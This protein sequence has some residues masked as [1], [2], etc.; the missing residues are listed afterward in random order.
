MVDLF[1][2]AK[3][4]MDRRK[5]ISPGGKPRQIALSRRNRRKRRMTEMV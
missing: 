5:G 4:E 2:R 1:K 3:T